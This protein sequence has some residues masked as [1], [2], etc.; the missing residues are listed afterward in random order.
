MPSAT[1]RRK[2]TF[3]REISAPCCKLYMVFGSV[4][5][6]RDQPEGPLSSAPRPPQGVTVWAGG[7]EKGR[8]GAFCSDLVTPGACPPPAGGSRRR[9]FRARR[10]AKPPAGFHNAEMVGARHVVPVRSTVLRIPGRR[11]FAP[12]LIEEV[13]DEGDLVDRH[14]LA[15]SGSFH[16]GEA[17]AIG[18][19]IE[20][21]GTRQ[22]GELPGRPQPRFVGAERV[23][24]GRVGGNHDGVVR[25]AIKKR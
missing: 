9:F 12:Q 4:N 21:E 7:E 6:R 15:G 14:S 24:G 19:Q 23:P 17:L 13:E 18:V 22:F 16:D 1:A 5:D 8:T 2:P 25:G 10:S 11:C 3:Q 20:V